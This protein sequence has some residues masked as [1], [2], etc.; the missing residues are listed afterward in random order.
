MLLDKLKEHG[1]KIMFFVMNILVVSTGVLFIKQKNTEQVS[2]TI[3]ENDA[4]KYKAAVDY[5]LQAQQA[6]I[7][8]QQKKT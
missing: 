4:I 7:T 5:A 6:V 2:A 1:E 8:D 3:T